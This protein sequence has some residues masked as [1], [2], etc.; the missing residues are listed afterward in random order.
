MNNISH[1]FEQ[2]IA[3]HDLSSEEMQVMMTACMRG[4][5]SDAQIAA[6]LVLMRKKG[7]TI[8]E[9][10]SAATIMRDFSHKID[11]GSNLIDIVG[12]GGDGKNTFNI[13]TLSAIV[14]AA[15]GARV[16]KHGNRSVSSSSGSSDLLQQAGISLS[17]TDEQLKRCLDKH[18]I[19][20]LFAP[21]FHPALVHAR[22]ARQELG[23]RSFFNLLGPVLNPAQ[24]SR[25]VVGVF[26]KRWQQALAQVLAS[27]GSQRAMIVTSRDGLDEV[28]IT[29]PS[30]ILEYHL[31]R[32]KQWTLDPKAH[33]CHHP[34]LDGILVNSPAE[35]LAC[36]ARVLAAEPGPA[37][38]VVVLNAGLALYCA[39][40]AT[41]YAAGITAARAA[42]DSGKAKALFE[43]LRAFSL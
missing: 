37:R 17:L 19:C 15:S 29:E 32:Y 35:S 16:A 41:D 1:I 24:V 38:D 30:D 20:F 4:E 9:L 14:A 43:E 23:I 3:N 12:T 5:L 33:G 10:S 25:Q 21:N 28:S 40:I 36:I 22:K 8:A 34:S 13:S 18:H 7:E 26:E 42:L 27:L 31:G 2:L 6:F 39:G 11:L